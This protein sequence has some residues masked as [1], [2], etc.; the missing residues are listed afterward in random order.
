MLSTSKTG[1]E[2]PVGQREVEMREGR[3]IG[4]HS[5]VLAIGLDLWGDSGRVRMAALMQREVV[6][7]RIE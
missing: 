6:P 1:V 4:R 7:R 3:G 2:I 5:A